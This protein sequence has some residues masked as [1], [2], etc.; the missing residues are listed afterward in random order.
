MTDAV[1]TLHAIARQVSQLSPSD[2]NP[3]HFAEQRSEI[4]AAIMRLASSLR[5][6]LASPSPPPARGDMPAPGVRTVSGARGESRTLV[7]EARRRG[8]L[9]QT[10]PTTDGQG[11][12]K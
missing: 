7:V 10:V 1:A 3:G 6:P 8:R 5:V 9:V 11:V 12:V 2:R 4:V